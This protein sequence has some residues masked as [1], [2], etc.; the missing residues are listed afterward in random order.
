MLILYAK[1]FFSRSDTID[2][3]KN[4]SI[5]SSIQRNDEILNEILLMTTQSSY[6]DQSLELHGKLNL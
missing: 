6:S 4:E 3:K 2:V 5:K 1:I